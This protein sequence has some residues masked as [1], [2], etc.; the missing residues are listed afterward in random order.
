MARDTFKKTFWLY[1]KKAIT[2]ATEIIT[3]DFFAVA[4]TTATNGN[5]SKAGGVSAPTRILKA[6]LRF[7]IAQATALTAAQV[8]DLTRLITNSRLLLWRGEAIVYDAPGHV[9][10]DISIQSVQGT[11]ASGYSVDYRTKCD[12]IVTELIYKDSE[13]IKPQLITPACATGF[14]SGVVSPIVAFKAAID[15]QQEIN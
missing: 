5:I 9:F 3:T 10:G 11:A 1:E 15:T 12:D 2:F 14:S 13:V 8:D 6:S 4:A 7:V